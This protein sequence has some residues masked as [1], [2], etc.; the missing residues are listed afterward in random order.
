M[1]GTMQQYRKLQDEN[2]Q[3]RATIVNMTKE[4]K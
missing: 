4:P 1:D 2:H 3:L